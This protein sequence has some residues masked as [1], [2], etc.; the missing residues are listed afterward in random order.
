[1]KRK[2]TLSLCRAIPGRTL[3][4]IVTLLWC[5]V[6]PVSSL[7][8]QTTSAFRIAYVTTTSLE[9]STLRV[10]E[11]ENTLDRSWPVEQR[12]G[13]GFIID[14]H[15]FSLS[16]SESAKN[17]DLMIRIVSSTPD[18][19]Y[20]AGAA[21][22]TMAAEITKTI[23]IIF[24]CK[25]NPGPTARLWRLVENLCFPERNITG[26]TRY[27]MR[28]FSGSEEAAFCGKPLPPNLVRFE[29]LN[30]W[31]FAALRDAI[32]KQGARVALIHGE[33]YDEDKWKNIQKAK[34]VGLLAVPIKLTRDSI[35]TLP[36]IYLEGQFDGGLIVASDLLDANTAQL[37]R[38]T[39]KIPKPT[40]F[41][42]D[43]ADSGAW[44]HYGTKVDLADE[45]AR[46]IVPLLQG[47][48]VRE[49]PV[50]FP[51]E[52]ELVV[53]HKLAKEHGWTFPKA[54]LLYPQR[55]PKLQ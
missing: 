54:F 39:S 16:P 8:A 36:R 28:V 13:R 14:I 12:G 51:K 19:I 2:P 38:V 21:A 3:L 31:R 4:L 15:P 7:Y 17:R 29:N 47:K 9:V 55:E 6:G 50:S 37:I 49:L 27:D 24:G 18:I 40:M 33:N 26:F 44:M 48:S 53:N 41:P 20:A 42:W 45:A 32:G 46:Y 23:P 22:A 35:D 34:D 1:V 10:R 11:L 43:E 52:Y 25:C 30:A 5:I